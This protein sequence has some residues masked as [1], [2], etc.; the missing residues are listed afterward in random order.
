MKKVEIK[1][2]NIVN[3]LPLDTF[4]NNQALFNDYIKLK[5]LLNSTVSPGHLA[6][7]IRQLKANLFYQKFK[8]DADPL[9]LKTLINKVTDF[10]IIEELLHLPDIDYSQPE[11]KFLDQRIDTLSSF[12]FLKQE[13]LELQKEQDE[14]DQKDS[15]LEE[16]FFEVYLEDLEK[17]KTI[18]LSESTSLDNIEWFFESDLF[19][20]MLGVADSFD[21]EPVDIYKGL[22]ENTE[23]K[24]EKEFRQHKSLLRQINNEKFEYQE[25]YGVLR[26]S[27]AIAESIAFHI[28]IFEKF[29]TLKKLSPV[30]RKAFVNNLIKHDDYFTLIKFKR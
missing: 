2:D 23:I 25:F 13:F 19:E 29:S 7:I 21:V 12:F 5:D 6:E 28:S 10:K 27:S 11:E 20:F 15:D 16:N 22:L 1:L 18:L 24:T 14:N 17:L 8:L 3:S 4:S 30:A 26:N 9:F